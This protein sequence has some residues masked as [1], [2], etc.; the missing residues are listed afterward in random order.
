MIGAIFDIAVNY[1]KLIEYDINKLNKK[2]DNLDFSILDISISDSEL[3]NKLLKG[4][5]VSR[6]GILHKEVEENCG[7]GSIF[8]HYYVIINKAN[9]LVD[10]QAILDNFSK[11][12]TT[13]NIGYI[14]VNDNIEENIGIVNKYIKATLMDVKVHPYKYKKFFVPILI[15][16]DKIYYVKESSVFMDT[17]GFGV[18]EGI[19]IINDKQ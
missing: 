3:Y 4:R 10:I 15:T 11:G 6:N 1:K 12:M 13:Y 17:Y 5:Y 16:K 2:I 19:R 9:E 18:V 7:E 14:F 8:N